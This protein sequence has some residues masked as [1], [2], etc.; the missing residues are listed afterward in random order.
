METQHLHEGRNNKI[1]RTVRLNTR[2]LAALGNLTFLHRAAE[3]K[4]KP[5][6][7]HDLRWQ[8]MAVDALCMADGGCFMLGDPDDDDDYYRAD[9]DVRTLGW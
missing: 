5:D 6:P 4:R 7:E 1:K 3:N 2:S 9:G 8:N